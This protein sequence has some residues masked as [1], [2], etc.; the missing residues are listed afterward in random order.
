MMAENTVPT[1][2]KGSDTVATQETT[3]AQE[4]YIRPPVDIFDTADGLVLVADLPGVK[5]EDLDIQVHDSVLS[6]TGRTHNAMPGTVIYREYELANFFRE[7]QIG[8]EID[9]DRIDAE[10]KHGVLTL[11]LKKAAKA[12]PKKIEVKFS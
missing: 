3:R 4:Q 7:F 5:R 9:Q 12:P 2:T 1:P 11:T 10:L 6:I 8:T